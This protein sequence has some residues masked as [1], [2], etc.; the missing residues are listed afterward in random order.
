MS[1]RAPH[2]LL[3]GL[4]LLFAGTEAAGQGSSCDLISSLRVVSNQT[5]NARVSYVSAPRFECT[6][7]TRIE[8]D[9]SVTFEATSFPQLFGDV[10]FRDDHRELY[11]DRAQYFSRVGRLQAQGSVRLINLEDGS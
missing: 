5:N 10:I 3:V 6:D 9:S 8:A 4:A 7:G 11:A 1:S 2:L